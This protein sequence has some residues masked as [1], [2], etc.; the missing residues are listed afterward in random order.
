MP[1][2]VTPEAHAAEFCEHLTFPAVEHAGGHPAAGGYRLE[3]VHDYRS[4]LLERWRHPATGRKEL[5]WFTRDAAGNAIPGLRGTALHELQMYRES[6]ARAALAMG[7][8]VVLVESESSVDAIRSVTAT[9]WAGSATS[10]PV[11]RLQGALGADGAGVVLVPDAD[12]A[13]IT[14]AAGLLATF[15]GMGLLM[16]DAGEDARDL[17]RRVGGPEFERKVKEVLG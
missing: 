10:V 3:A 15:P 13:G 1:E 8:P 7:E 11:Q 14:C 12:D 6:E 5:R 2:G 17:Y 16:P 9:T 4:H